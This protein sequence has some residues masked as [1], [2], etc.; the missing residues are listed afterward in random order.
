MSER[1][2]LCAGHVALDVGEMLCPSFQARVVCRDD[3]LLAES[4]LECE[5]ALLAIST[6][7]YAQKSDSES[8]YA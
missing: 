2:S 1:A 5:H 7:A 4:S 8:P 3:T 6:S